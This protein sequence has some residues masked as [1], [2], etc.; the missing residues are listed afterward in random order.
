LDSNDNQAP[1]ATTQAIVAIVRDVVV[2]LATVAAGLWA[3]AQYQLTGPTSARIDYEHR[4][5]DSKQY[6]L[7]ITLDATAI[8]DRSGRY[9]V[10]HV[11]LSTLD[12][13]QLGVLTE[14]PCMFANRLSLDGKT[15]AITTKKSGMLS[16]RFIWV[17]GQ[18]K[19]GF[20]IVPG[21]VVRSHFVFKIAQPGFYLVQFRALVV[22]PSHKQS[23]WGTQS[24]VQVS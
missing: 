11:D 4:L 20:A 3:L 24:I 19:R 6:G 12:S 13:Q 5:A 7:Q 18:H 1:Y 10:G 2:T 22:F 17:D 16:Q 8:H 23:W 15:G 9:I 14:Q 21:R